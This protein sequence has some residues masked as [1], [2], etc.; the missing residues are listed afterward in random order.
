VEE[1]FFYILGGSLVVIALVLS[2]AGLRFEGFPPSRGIMVAIAVGV[3]ALVGATATFAWM[4]AEEEQDDH[5]AELAEERAAAAE[6]VAAEVVAAQGGAEEG[7]VEDQA[8]GED[9]AEAPGEPASA[10]AEG[11][12][13]FESA[14][15]SGCHTL[16]A[17]GSS[18]QVG[19]DLDGALKGKSAQYIET[20]IVDPNA[21]IAEGFPP[22]VM[23]QNFGS[24]LTPEELTALVD[25]LVESVE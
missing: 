12:A 2:A 11:A 16:A 17:A 7:P 10:A 4:N 21:E 25:Y 19:P 5:A 15:C 9:V 6:E 22:D 18:A 24:T 8:G 23:P 13:V 20:S 1:T 3:L 14:G